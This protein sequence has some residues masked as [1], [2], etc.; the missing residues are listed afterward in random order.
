MSVARGLWI[1]CLSVRNIATRIHGMPISSCSRQHPEDEEIR[2]FDES[3]L[4]NEPFNPSYNEWLEGDYLG[5]PSDLHTTCQAE[6]PLITRNNVGIGFMALNSDYTAISQ[7]NTL[8]RRLADLETNVYK[9]FCVVTSMNRDRFS[10]GINP[11]E[12]LMFKESL[13]LLSSRKDG[14]VLYKVLQRALD[15][16]LN[17]VCDLSYLIHSYKKPLIV[18]ANGMTAGY[19][20]CLVS[21]ANVSACYKHSIMSCNNL[22]HGVPFLGGQSY[23]LAMLRGSLGKYLALTGKELKGC[24]LVWSGLVK[25]YISPDAL[26]V[27]QMTSERLVEMPEKET[28]HQIQE[29]YM[30]LEGKYSLEKLE[31]LIHEHFSLP[32]VASIL[33][34]L[35]KGIS[36]KKIRSNTS[37]SED[38]VRKWEME[39]LDLMTRNIKKYKKDAEYALKLINDITTYKLEVLKTLKVSPRRWN[40]LQQFTYRPAVTTQDHNNRELLHSIQR[41]ILLEALHLEVASFLD[42]AEKD[43][44][45]SQGKLWQESRFHNNPFT[46]CYRSGFSL[47]SL[48]SLRTLHP[49]Y[50]ARTGNDHDTL[51]M[52]HYDER[53][54]SDFLQREL[55]LMK[56]ILT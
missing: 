44:K 55:M 23:V 8:Y 18:Y 47:S 21:L 56:R 38:H 12:L 27:M 28:E 1:R 36:V 49:D 14:A 41:E 3:S 22:E 51:L 16:Y 25:R 33:N 31:W 10:Y 37:L 15:D 7:V 29:H 4:L 53:W 35:E 48:P 20:T 34:S 46:P 39:S 54:S 19:A 45:D 52:K 42:R 50:D 11:L 13:Q 24:D 6:S 32:N 43:M 5:A 9:R 2:S 26:S 40:E 17:N 30:P